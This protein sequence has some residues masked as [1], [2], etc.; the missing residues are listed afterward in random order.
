LRAGFDQPFAFQM[1]IG[2]EGCT[3]TNS[4]FLAQRAYGK[5]FVA[6]FQRSFLYQPLDAIGNFLV[7]MVGGDYRFLH[8][9]KVFG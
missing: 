3:Q 4:L 9:F 5:Q 8:E 1:I 2:L 6:Y 7:Q